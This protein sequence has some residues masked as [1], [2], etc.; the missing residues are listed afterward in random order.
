[1]PQCPIA[2]DANAFNRLLEVV[3]LHACATFHQAKWSGS[4]V[5]LLTEKKRSDDAENNTAVA[6]AD[7]KN[8]SMLFTNLDATA[9]LCVCGT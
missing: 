9:H 2:G 7:S 5:I 6:S 4:G 8:S 3:R 1:M